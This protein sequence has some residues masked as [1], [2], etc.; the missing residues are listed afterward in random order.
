[1]LPKIVQDQRKKKLELGFGISSGILVFGVAIFL[2]IW[3]FPFNKPSSKQVKYDCNGATGICQAT[4]DS[5]AIYDTEAECSADCR[6]TPV[7]NPPTPGPSPSPSPAPPPPPPSKKSFVYIQAGPAGSSKSP[8]TENATGYVGTTAYKSFPVTN[9]G[10]ETSAIETNSEASAT[11]DTDLVFGFTAFCEQSDKRSYKDN[12]GTYEKYFPSVCYASL[13]AISN[14]ASWL[15][16]TQSNSVSMDESTK[17]DQGQLYFATA[18]DGLAENKGLQSACDAFGNLFA[19][20]VLEDRFKIDSSYLQNYNP[21]HK[22]ANCSVN[23]SMADCSQYDGDE[24]ACTSVS[25]Q[26]CKYE[27]S[28]CT[29]ANT[30]AETAVQILR[31]QCQPNTTNKYWSQGMVINKTPVNSKINPITCWSLSADEKECNNQVD[32]SGIQ[33]SYQNNE[34]LYYKVPSYFTYCEA[35]AA[36]DPTCKSGPTQKLDEK[37]YY[38]PQYI[39]GSLSVRATNKFAINDKG[40]TCK[41]GQ[42]PARYKFK[43]STEFD[44]IS[45]IAACVTQTDLQSVLNAA[46][47]SC[48][49]LRKS[50]HGTDLKTD[51]LQV[52]DVIPNT[53]LSNAQGNGFEIFKD[54]L[55]TSTYKNKSMK[56]V[57]L[58]PELVTPQMDDPFY[59]AGQQPLIQAL[60]FGCRVCDGGLTPC[61]VEIS[62]FAA[63]PPQEWYSKY[64]WALWF[65]A[66]LLLFAVVALVL[67]FNI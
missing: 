31:Q 28:K 18:A 1:M 53:L 43:Y 61:N 60:T 33:C 49:A 41:A 20:T 10:L 12:T 44:T 58:P 29:N 17:W 50:I 51:Y 59:D 37:K 55:T 67:K 63:Q 8:L 26:A 39:W 38:V 6:F 45:D 66:V 30:K 48:N 2:I 34:C 32:Y 4:T 52:N 35:E 5:L 40:G 36:C 62:A 11:A 9:G 24:K 16:G 64:W 15:N 21:N 42:V 25:G 19:K 57:P 13:P 3:F 46:R 56:Y 23:I 47:L 65:G 54:K 7:P 22:T 27:K 14:F